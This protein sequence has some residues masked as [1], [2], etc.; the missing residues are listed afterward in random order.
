S[1]T[2]SLH[3]ALVYQP[4]ELFLYPLYNMPRQENMHG[5]YVLARDLLRNAGYTQ[6][7]MRRFVLNPAPSAA[8]ESCGFENSLALGAGGRSYLG[9]LHYCS[10]WS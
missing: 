6:T 8:A 7:S 5:Y 10:P 9:N 4:E 1:L 3:Q 2:E